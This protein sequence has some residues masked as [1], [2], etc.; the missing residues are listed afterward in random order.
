MIRCFKTVAVIDDSASGISADCFPWRSS[1]ECLTNRNTS[2]FFSEEAAIVPSSCLRDGNKNFVK[3]YLMVFAND[4]RDLD[5]EFFHPI[6]FLLGQ[7]TYCNCFWYRQ[8]LNPLSLEFTGIK[9]K[10]ISKRKLVSS[11]DFFEITSGCLFLFWRI[12]KIM[13][14]FCW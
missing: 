6:W 1:L 4:Q 9:L 3:L 5:S 14:N 8:A 2:A 10:F 13:S 7:M 11:F 12:A